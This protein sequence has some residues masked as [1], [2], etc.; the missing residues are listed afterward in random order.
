MILTNI[1][2]KNFRCHKEFNVPLNK[3]VTVISGG[4][5]SGKS[6]IFMAL[7]FALWGTRNLKPLVT[8]GATDMSVRVVLEHNGDNIV[9]FREAVKSGS[10]FISR[11]SFEINGISQTQG[12][13]KET[14]EHINETLGTED[15]AYATYLIRQGH[16]KE[17]IAAPPSR[18]REVLGKLLNLSGYWKVAHEK[19]IPPLRQRQ[20][21]Y[22]RTKQ[23]LETRQGDLEGLPSITQYQDDI[24]RDSNLLSNA[25]QAEERY[26]TQLTE[27]SKQEARIQ[28]R[29]KAI[30]DK[31]AEVD[32][33]TRQINDNTQ[34][35]NELDRTLKQA[36]PRAKDDVEF[37]IKGVQQQI[38]QS[39]G[40]AKALYDKR[41]KLSEQIGNDE[42]E[43]TK[44][45]AEA[46]ELKNSPLYTEWER[47]INEYAQ[48]TTS[49]VCRTCGGAVNNEQKERMVQALTERANALKAQYQLQRVQID[50][51]TGLGNAKRARDR[52]VE[53]KL[54]EARA[55]EQG[56][57]RRREMDSKLSRAQSSISRTISD[58]K[59]QLEPLQ[60]ELRKVDVYASECANA[61]GEVGR[62]KQLNG[63]LETTRKKLNEEIVAFVDDGDAALANKIQQTLSAKKEQT[64]KIS[65]LNNS[66]LLLK[67]P[68]RTARGWSA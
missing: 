23:L 26:T 43:I 32:R 41:Q 15:T 21:E 27:L 45:K 9:V 13:I 61:K 20:S 49:E 29:R 14:Q 52:L 68:W 60:R 36:P 24:K 16:L 18:R 66:L 63:E 39:E 22:D 50:N 46:Q 34:R 57:V 6:S 55:L 17:F 12:V 25:K 62:L 1:E 33:T 56:M 65:T 2:L 54:A 67:T 38:E 11:L 37:E 48:T 19:S 53:E 58:S 31:R 30:N 35:L 59:G 28:D 42:S 3:G 51:D 47:L 44:R 10:K 8:T 40:D 4:N 64:D 7:I 5:G